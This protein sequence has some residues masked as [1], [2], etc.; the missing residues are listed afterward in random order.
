MKDLNYGFCFIENKWSRQFP[1]ARALILLKQIYVVIDTHSSNL[2]KSLSIF[3]KSVIKQQRNKYF[4]PLHWSSIATYPLCM[5]LSAA[6]GVSFG[7][8]YMLFNQS[9]TLIDAFNVKKDRFVIHQ[10]FSRH[11][12]FYLV[13]RYRFWLKTGISRDNLWKRGKQRQRRRRVDGRK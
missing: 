8:E 11:A 9:M 6:K 2:L 5:Y 12:C 7:I 4:L 1:F 10:M 13:K 3:L